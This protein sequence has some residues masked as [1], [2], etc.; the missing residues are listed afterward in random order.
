VAET[1][2]GRAFLAR[3]STDLEAVYEEI[4]ALERVARPATPPPRARAQAT[5]LLALAA[6]G[7]LAELILARVLRRRLP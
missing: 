7:L 6:G 5:P 3:R 4:A 1:T 2:G